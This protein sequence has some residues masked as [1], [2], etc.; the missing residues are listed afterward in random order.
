M[1]N[2]IAPF[3]TKLPGVGTT[4]FTVMS[5]LA[6]EHGAINLAQGFPDFPCSPELVELVS[7]AMQAGHNQYAPME[8]LL[9]L[10]EQIAQKTEQCYGY[11]PDPI[12]EITVTSGATEAIFA[13][14]TAVVHPGDEVIVLEPCYDSYLPAIEL[15]GG[16]ALTIPL[17][18][19]DYSIDWALVKE[20]VTARTKLLIINSP[21][22]PTASVLSAHDLR[23]LKDIV[24]G[25][26]MLILSDEVYEHLIFD[27]Q[28]HY[29]LLAD[30]QLRERSFVVSSFGKTFHAT[31][32]KTGYCIAP[33][34]LSKELRKVHQFLTFAGFTPVQY[35]L[36]EYLKTPE[37]YWSL[38]E[39]YQQKRDLFGEWM[40]ATPFRLLP[41]RGT[42]FQLA[43][44]AHLTEE[45]DW[46]FALRLT[47]EA[48]VATIPVS[49]FY[50]DQTDHRVIRF[51][52]AKKEET[53]EKAVERLVKYPI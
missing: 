7:Q 4:I 20:A 24:S 44:I 23:E 30:A 9:A 29:S 36:A 19:T 33:T 41:S 32:W 28:T 12:A 51:C 43:S 3:A 22:N 34:G 16:T 8:G 52:F 37:H 1:P 15:S 35:A 25:T 39:F 40:R 10:R 50:R 45:T 26:D 27:G 5:R 21:H 6:A 42:Y 17:R 53:L 47:T 11:A 2:R 18:P 49:V 48:G 31:G 46:D 38:P 14:I 13:A